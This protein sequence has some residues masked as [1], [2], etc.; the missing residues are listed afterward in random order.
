LNKEPFLEHTLQSRAFRRIYDKRSLDE[1]RERMG[2]PANDKLC[3]Q[4]VWF[5]QT[6]LLGSHG[7]MDQIAEAI[8]KIHTHA[9][10]LAPSAA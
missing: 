4:G 2:C 5:T 1:Y 9:A 10:A 6:M 7:D 8:R 3:E